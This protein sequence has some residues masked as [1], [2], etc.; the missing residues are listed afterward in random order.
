[1]KGLEP[2]LASE[3]R[4]A[5]ADAVEKTEELVGLLRE[6]NADGQYDEHIAESQALIDELRAAL[7]ADA[8]L[9]AL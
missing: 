3:L 1:M 6:R 7:T 8:E 4:D 2:P 5:T 9:K